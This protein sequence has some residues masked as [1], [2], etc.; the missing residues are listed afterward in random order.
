MSQVAEGRRV[1]LHF[2][3]K[4]ADGSVID[5]TRGGDPAEFVVGDGNLLPGFEAALLGAEAGEQ[6]LV[7]LPPEHAFG[8]PNPENIRRMPRSAFAGMT[9]EPG[10]IVSFAEPS[11][12][13]LPGVVKRIGPESVEVDFNHPLAGR[14]ILFEATIIAVE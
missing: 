4:L 11:G 3:L 7:V 10:T 8:E 6:R 5:E 14:E 9:L 13:E 2:S 1:R 12:S